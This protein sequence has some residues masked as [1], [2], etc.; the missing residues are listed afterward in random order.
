M[1]TPT[2]TSLRSRVQQLDGR[3]IRVIMETLYV[4]VNIITVGFLHGVHSQVFVELLVRNVPGSI[5][6]FS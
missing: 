2:S 4:I 3:R 1:A 6:N 5:G